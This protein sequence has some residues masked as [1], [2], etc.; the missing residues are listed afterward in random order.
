[1]QEISLENDNVQ[2]RL[3]NHTSNAVTT[4]ARVVINFGS[5]K[6]PGLFEALIDSLSYLWRSPI[7]AEIT[8]LE[9]EGSA[10][11]ALLQLN[12]C[13]SAAKDGRLPDLVITIVLLN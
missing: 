4:S 13:Y 5:A 11:S 10:A 3:Q 2:K 1:M 7:S 8:Y 9:A 12:K 6:L